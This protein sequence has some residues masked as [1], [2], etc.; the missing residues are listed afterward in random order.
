MEKGWFAF[1][2]L[3]RIRLW[4]VIVCLECLNLSHGVGQ[5]VTWTWRLAFVPCSAFNHL[6]Y[7]EML[8][9]LVKH[10]FSKWYVSFSCSS[11]AWGPS[12][13]SCEWSWVEQHQRTT[14]VVPPRTPSYA[15]PLW[16]QRA[17]KQHQSKPTFISELHRVPLLLALISPKRILNERFADAAPWCARIMHLDRQQRSP[18]S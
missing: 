6:P 11:A 18:W 2:R 7:H 5:C 17:C 14:F 1:R 9:S 16:T 8:L 13:P 10:V 15:F 3:S 4:H 12:A